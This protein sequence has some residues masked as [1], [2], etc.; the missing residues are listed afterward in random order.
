M[1]LTKKEELVALSS[2]M[3]LMG[4]EIEASR[5]KLEGFL[6]QGLTLSSQEILLENAVF[7]RLSGEFSRLEQRFLRLEQEIGADS[8]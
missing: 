4:L 7:N 1:E 6:E 2:A 3:Y 8:P 5:L